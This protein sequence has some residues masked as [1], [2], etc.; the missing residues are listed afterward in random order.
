MSKV[1]KSFKNGKTLEYGKG[2]FDNWCVYVCNQNGKKVAPKDTDYF[3]VLKEFSFKYGVDKV[4]NDFIEIFNITGKSV[5]R[6]VLERI[7]NIANTYE[8]KDSI[9]IDLVFS[10]IYL[11]MIAEENKENT[12][13]GKR[14]K[15]LGIHTLLKDD[16][17]V[18]YAANFMRRIPRKK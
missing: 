17:S 5:E 1:I 13:L 6:E 11:G 9:K 15:R 3:K 14:I 7:T 8:E 4:Y 18:E 10:V 16:S 12:V 2:S